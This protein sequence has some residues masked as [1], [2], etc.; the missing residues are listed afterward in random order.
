MAIN[1]ETVFDAVLDVVDVCEFLSKKP[2][3]GRLFDGFTPFNINIFEEEANIF[4][5][6]TLDCL[7]RPF[8]VSW[9]S[10][11][12]CQ[13]TSIRSVPRKQARGVGFA[14]NPVEATDYWIYGKETVVQTI[15]DIPDKKKPIARFIGCKQCPNKEFRNH[16]LADP[17]SVIWSL[18]LQFWH[19]QVP[20]V[21]LKPDGCDVGFTIELQTL[22]DAR[23]MFK[24]RDVP[25]GRQRRD[26]LRHWVKNHQRKKP[27]HNNESELVEVRKYLRGK[28]DFD[29]MGFEGRI[30]HL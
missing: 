24:L 17:I 23:K 6:A 28:K 16:P 30:V 10:E 18:G 13:M 12:T 7:D 26:A 3:L 14:I 25:V 20:V 8:R 1:D 11:K 22:D 2:K 9:Y 27:F 29:W 5:D 4:T 15:F 21:Y 19:E